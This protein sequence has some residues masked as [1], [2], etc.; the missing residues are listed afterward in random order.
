M[1]NLDQIEMRFGVH[2][3]LLNFP[4]LSVLF[5]VFLKAG[6][7]RLGNEAQFS[8]QTNDEGVQHTDGFKRHRD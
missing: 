5:W 6:V 8:C 2:R 1:I 7:G 4:F 3:N